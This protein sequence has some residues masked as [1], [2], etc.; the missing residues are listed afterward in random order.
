MNKLSN[1]LICPLLRKIVAMPAWLE[2]PQLSASAC[3][4]VFRDMA[5]SAL[6]AALRAPLD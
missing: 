5:L 1:S 4:G 3:L 6:Q 2:A